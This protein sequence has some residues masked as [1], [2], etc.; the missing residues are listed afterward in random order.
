MLTLMSL[1][2]TALLWLLPVGAQPDP[3]FGVVQ[4]IVRIKDGDACFNV[5]VNIVSKDGKANVTVQT[6]TDGL[7]SRLFPAGE[8][9]VSVLGTTMPI[10]VKAGETT[11]ANVN[12]VPKGVLLRVTMDDPGPFSMNVQA[13]YKL[14]DGT[15]RGTSAQ[16]LSE[17]QF[18]FPQVPPEAKMFAAVVM[19]QCRSYEEG[20]GH[21]VRQQWTFDT[22]AEL[23]T[24]ELKAGKPT[25]LRL[26]VLDKDGQPV[27]NTQVTPTV[28]V[29]Y[30]RDLLWGEWSD[31]RS[32]QT[33]QRP[34]ATTDDAGML[35]LGYFPPFTYQVSIKSEAGNGRFAKVALAADG[36]VTPADYKLGQGMRTLVQTVFDAAGKPAPNARVQASYAWEDKLVLLSAQADAAGKITWKDLPA[37]PVI[38]WGD[39]TP[40]GI[41]SAE[42]TEAAKPLA[43]PT[44]GGR[45]QFEPMLPNDETL[46]TFRV[47][48]LPDNGQVYT[49]MIGPRMRSG[50]TCVSGTRISLVG[51]ST[52]KPPRTVLLRDVYLP[53]V[54][55]LG[56]DYP[57]VRLTHELKVEEGCRAQLRLPAPGVSRLTALPVDPAARRLLSRSNL[58]L[59]TEQADGSWM[60]VTPV[61]GPYLL[62]PDL[63]TPDLPAAQCPQ[64]T[65][66]PGE[67]TVDVKLPAPL[68][69]ALP[70]T[71]V[72]WTT[73]V[74]P[75]NA[76]SLTVAPGAATMP[77]YGPREALL[78]AWARTRPDQLLIWKAGD[79]AS[80]TL[81]LTRARVT[82]ARPDNQPGQDRGRL[83]PLLPTSRQQRQQSR[84]ADTAC[85]ES[86]S[87]TLDGRGS[88]TFKVWPVPYLYSS[89]GRS[90]DQAVPLP[91][92]GGAETTVTLDPNR[93]NR[94]Q[95]RSVRL[96]FPA[97][98]EAQRA[99]SRRN[100]QIEYRLDV[101]SPYSNSLSGGERTE[102]WLSVPLTATR[103]S[104]FWPGIGLSGELAIPAGDPNRGET[105]VVVPAWQ[106]G[107]TLTVT[108]L[109]SSDKPRANE[110]VT[111][112]TSYGIGDRGDNLR[113]QTDALGKV[114]IPGLAPGPMRL[115]VDG[116]EGGSWTVTIGDKATQ[117]VTLK[118]LTQ[119][120][121]C[122]AS[123]FNNSRGKVWWKPANAAPI[124]VATRYGQIRSFDIPTGPGELWNV[125]CFEGIA[126]YARLTLQPGD[127]QMGDTDGP[128]LGLIFPL[129]DDLALPDKVT[130]V[131][132]GPWK[133][134][135]VEFSLCQW[136]PSTVLKQIVGQID[137]V[138]PGEWLVR[139]DTPAGP[140]EQTVTITDAGGVARWD[141]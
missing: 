135:T 117:E 53:I 25:V 38:V 114:T 6:D 65:V 100:S 15:S 125:D 75:L 112:G 8:A 1:A 72:S 13:A 51:I 124:P 21:Y 30:P 57:Q 77:V 66:A 18:L 118:S 128:S 23:R 141:K 10:T 67:T 29:G 93:R 95:N 133:D 92:A 111:L 39:T 70:G 82:F 99:W 44:P 42:A 103:V 79:A 104:L 56:E 84:P 27:R 71:E 90:I 16:K 64:I 31:T 102:S 11:E 52:T 109:N 115:H 131:G 108:L 138:P 40:A 55:D 37:V 139:V 61:A 54:E 87:I 121:R 140:V 4:G 28:Q 68:F 132:R 86:Y 32:R 129:K 110:Q 59:L 22:Q 81:A 45:V 5:A 36:T 80:R 50:Y 136:F 83:L 35:D 49:Y 96:K 62:L 137:A 63:Y 89:D 127:N 123:G 78:A 58:N 126:K 120:V 85:S 9:T 98:T 105:V 34:A 46:P 101:E 130:L 14:K 12:V 74:S 91:A 122:Y 113:L 24:L 2:L 26:R 60:L 134:V 41:I 43:P 88:Y 19:G 17:E 106:P 97:L 3:G 76:S 69:S 119:S 73:P 47:A 94:S 116:Q 7:F 33:M 48:L 107:C 20:Y